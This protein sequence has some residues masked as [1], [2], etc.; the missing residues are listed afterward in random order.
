M[1]SV[2]RVT[3]IEKH[4]D[5]YLTEN[6]IDKDIQ[7]YLQGVLWNRAGTGIRI[8]MHKNCQ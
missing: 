6:T 4:L 1:Y 3:N 5:Q 2:Q 8:L 7:Q